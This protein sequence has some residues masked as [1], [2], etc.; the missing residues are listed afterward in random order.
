MH[1]TNWKTPQ[2][3]SSAEP[4]V[5]CRGAESILVRSRG[6]D[7]LLALVSSNTNMHLVLQTRHTSHDSW[8]T[9]MISSLK[10]VVWLRLCCHCLGDH[11]S[12]DMF[13]TGYDY[14]NDI[15][16]CFM[17]DSSREEVGNLNPNPWSGGM[18]SVCA[19]FYS[20]PALTQLITNNCGHNV[21]L[22]KCSLSVCPIRE[23]PNQH[24]T[25]LHQPHIFCLILE[26]VSII[27]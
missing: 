7:R 17:M 6:Q 2:G 12:C 15:I 18:Q 4:S 1:N 22:Q 19:G 3:S 23:S 11:G 14:V 27:Q 25:A 8:W 16:V 20:S 24:E 5:R 21:A 10:E 13:M 9:L 26:E